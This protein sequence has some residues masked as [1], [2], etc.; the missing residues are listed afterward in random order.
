MDSGKTYTASSLILGLR[1]AGIRVAG[2]K[3]TGSAAGRDF[4][5]MHD[6]GACA[7]FDFVDGGY[8]STYL[9]SLQEL[10]RLYDVLMSN[11]VQHGA[12]WVV[13]EIADGLLQRETSALLQ[14]SEFT[15]TVSDWIFAAGDPLA[16]AG[17][18]RL[19]R[20]W[21][22]IPSAISGLVTMSPLGMREATEA[23]GVRCLTAAELQDP[24]IASVLDHTPA[25]KVDELQHVAVGT[26]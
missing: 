24:S 22:L 3:L 6:A 23:T 18:D 4:W 11:A 1:E 9:C 25:S 14:C 16:A 26:K 21:G 15:R 20:N 8:P 5:S 10:L 7:V 13:M 2:I 19:L 12:E 17:G